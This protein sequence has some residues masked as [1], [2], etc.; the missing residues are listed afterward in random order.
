LTCAWWSSLD[1]LHTHVVGLFWHVVGLF[2]HFDGLFW[3]VRGLFWHVCAGARLSYIWWLF[4]L[5]THTC[6][7]PLL[8]RNGA[9]VTF[10]G[11]LLTCLLTCKGAF[12]TCVCWSSFVV[13][14]LAARPTTL[15]CYSD[16]NGLFL[17]FGLLELLNFCGRVYSGTFD[18]LD[19]FTFFAF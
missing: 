11:A 9:L 12:L 8:T 4:W 13:Y 5:F 17:T 3:L 16:M 1:S 15:T 7:R 2:C 10:M 14:E 19:L 18:D 6:S